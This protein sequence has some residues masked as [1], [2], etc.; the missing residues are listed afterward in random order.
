MSSR[1][2]N[3]LSPGFRAQIEI[4]LSEAEFIGF[5]LLIYCTHRSLEAQ[6]RLYRNG[7]TLGQIQ[8]KADQLTQQ[9]NRQDLAMLLMDVGPQHGKKILTHAA[10]GQSYHNYGLAVDAVPLREGKPVWTIKDEAD[11]A[12]WVELGKLASHVSA[13]WGGNWDYFTDYP[14]IQQA[15]V[16][17]RE[18]ITGAVIAVNKT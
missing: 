11:K 1:D 4:M 6:A 7:R 18:L 16:N 8:A 13:E 12:L 15:N 9:F 17:W 5:D 2:I 14:H 10:P 3:D